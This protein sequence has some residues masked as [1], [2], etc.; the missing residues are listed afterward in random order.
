MS[1][2]IVDENGTTRDLANS[3]GLEQLRARASGA[4]LRLLDQGE[5]DE[6][7]RREI[8]ASPDTPA[9]VVSILSSLSGRVVLSDGVVDEPED[10][11]WRNLD[12]AMRF[13]IEKRGRRWVL[14]TRD[15]RRVLGRH[16]SRAEAEAQE[17]AIEIA[18]HGG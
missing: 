4:L 13:V 12:L 5:V 3:V 18:K 17:R 2:A 14:L 15:R 8:V 7:G 6:A 9:Q 16:S 10:E 1:Y 11:T